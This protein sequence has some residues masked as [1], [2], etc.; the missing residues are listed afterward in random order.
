MI[1][2]GALVAFAC[3][4]VFAALLGTGAPS[5]GA[6]AA[7]SNEAIRLAQHTTQ[8]GD[9]R[10]WERVS[11]AEKGGGDIVAEGKSIISA[12][13]GGA[14]TFD[15]RYGFADAV[16][17][18]NVGRR[19]YLAR[20]GAGGWSV[21]SVTPQSRPEALQAS[22]PGTHTEVFSSDLSRALVVG[23]DLPAAT[24][25]VPKRMNRYLEDTATGALSTISGSQRG[26]GEDP[27]QYFPNEFFNGVEF[28]GASDDL[29]HVTWESGTQLLPA[30]AAPGYPQGFEIHELFPEFPPYFFTVSNVY[31]WD[32][33]T[34]HLASILPDGSAAPEGAR[35][36]PGNESGTRGTNSADG[37]RQTF[38]APP[39]G[40]SQ[41]YLRIDHNR[42]A[43]ISES[44]NPNFAPPEEAQ[45][46]LFEGMTPD[47]RNVFFVTDSPL[48]EED[49]NTSADIYRW[50]DGPDPEHEQNL[51]LITDT[52]DA[53]NDPGSLGGTLIGM[54]NDGSRVY[55]HLV[56][57]KIKLWEEGNGIKT[58]DL[59]PRS[60]R[61][62]WL[63]LL[64]GGPGRVSPDGNWLA[65]LSGYV[66]LYDRQQGKLTTIAGDGR[67]APHVTGGGGVDNVGFRPHFLSDQG[68]L[69]FTSDE[70]LVP[71]DTNGVADVYE[72]D[73]P[74]G[75]LSLVTSG[76]GDQPME[77]ADASADGED[78]F[79]VTRAQLVP[80]DTDDF[81]DLYDA[82]VGGGFDEPEA[83]PVG[84]CS[85]E[86]CQA[87]SGASVS[88]PAI[89]SG[90]ATRGNLRQP[91]NA[92]CA[93][94]R[95]KVRRHG[96]V[97]CVKRHGGHLPKRHTRHARASQGGGK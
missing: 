77:F 74:T 87:V 57:A 62:G 72:Y 46:V 82:R 9:C 53:V 69:F 36:E 52:G 64:Y 84:P 93:R 75:K 78:V 86:A 89:A 25:S 17:S 92:R 76:K 4:A 29:S 18:A 63:T 79:F 44:E 41:L 94:N 20:R 43:L 16:G 96:K 85:G 71:G 51:T 11:P 19:T 40:T 23:Y 47:G 58:V 35:V 15:S 6:D 45:K 8:T 2:I 28:W 54:S 7:C 97:I 12:S 95:H 91:R 24:G 67:L 60:T 65:Y 1:L 55:L 73:G 3:A 14:V 37:S 88:G 90:A 50:T 34:L 31:T 10:A 27:I 83:S 61:P 49:K 59:V 48:L 33:G 26:N 68:K 56:T 81:A 38:L 80:S 22:G 5:A 21:H 42:T 32:E 13:G 66:R 39:F 30:G 70:A